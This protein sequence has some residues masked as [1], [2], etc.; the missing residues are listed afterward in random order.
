M[1]KILLIIL[2]NLLVYSFLT[3][4]CL[5]LRV[6]PVEFNLK[7]PPG[8]TKTLTFSVMNDTPSPQIYTFYAADWYRNEKG[9]NLFF[10]NSTPKRIENYSCK[11]WIEI[12]RARL[13]IPPDS[14]ET[15]K[16]N[17]KVPPQAK[18]TYWAIIFVEGMPRPVKH[19]G[20]TV[21]AVPRIGLKVYQTPPGTAVKEGRVIGMKLE[22]DNPLAFSLTFENSGNCNLRPRGYIQIKDV[23]GKTVRK[24]SISPFPI[25]PG[26]KRILHIKDKDTPLSPGVYQALGV[27]DYGGEL[28]R[29]GAV[30]YEIRQTA[31]KRER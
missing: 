2:I 24:I 14:A 22:S 7:I 13:E 21:M 28:R 16:F 1:K 18:G 31:Q 11:D 4:S 23:R 5:A 12:S 25:L 9:D 30:V 20:Y 19:R 8:E 6:S 26:F 27:I 10:E 17:L 29:S 15:V 3:S